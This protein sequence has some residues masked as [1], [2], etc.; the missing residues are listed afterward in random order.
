M[1]RISARQT[2]S[3][4]FK[5][6]T[7]TNFTKCFTTF[8]SL[9]QEDES[10]KHGNSHNG[11]PCGGHS[12]SHNHSPSHSHSHSHSN[13]GNVARVK[14]DKPM[15]MLAFTCKKCDTRSSHVI[16]KQAYEGGT[17]LVQCPGCKSRHLVADHLKIFSD[18]KIKLED[19][20]KAQGEG[21][22][23]GTEDLIFDDIPESLKSLIGHHAKDAPAEFQKKNK[24]PEE[25]PK[26]ADDSKN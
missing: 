19:I 10:N 9:R 16:S 25:P 18:N 2:V 11:V 14:M 26:I 8:Q 12:H 22:Q 13:D 23:T 21:I 24:I 6:R 4:L 7:Q 5:A 1:L 20:L 3:A 17:I 15:L